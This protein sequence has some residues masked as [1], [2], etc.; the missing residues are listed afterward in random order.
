VVDRVARTDTPGVDRAA[1]TAIGHQAAKFIMMDPVAARIKEIQVVGQRH[2]L[3]IKPTAPA[4]QALGRTEVPVSHAPHVDP[5]AR[6]VFN[7]VVGDFIV[8]ALKNPDPRAV[9]DPPA[10]ITDVIV[11]NAVPMAH[12]GLFGAAERPRAHIVA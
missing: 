10:A 6:H 12:V 3:A 11:E 1:V 2:C 9:A 5:V 7:Q 8:A 4:S